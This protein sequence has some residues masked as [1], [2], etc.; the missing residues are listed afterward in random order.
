MKR[1]FNVIRINGFK[2]LVIAAFVVGCLVAGF[3]IFPGWV[4]MNIWNYVSGFFYQMPSMQMIHGIMLWAII[5]LSAYALNKGNFS[6][7]FGTSVPMP[8]NEERIK[9][10]IK[11]INEKNAQIV[12]LD[13]FSD[14]DNEQSDL[15]ESHDDKMLNK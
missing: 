13:K 10:I 9:E 8:A 5:A 12:P 4:C 2:G 1:N 3:L 14:S 6:V 7:S 11:R 15:K